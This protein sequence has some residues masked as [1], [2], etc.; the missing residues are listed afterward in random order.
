MPGRIIMPAGVAVSILDVCRKLRII[1]SSE[2]ESSSLRV[3]RAKISRRKLVRR[4]KVLACRKNACQAFFENIFE[5]G[6]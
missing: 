1:I 6:M 4:L 5:N 3:L 2:R